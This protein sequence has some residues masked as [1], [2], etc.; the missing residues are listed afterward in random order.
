MKPKTV[1]RIK[2]GPTHYEVV[3]RPPPITEGEETN[4]I[5]RVLYNSGQLVIA[6]HLSPEIEILTILH[7]VFHVMMS[8]CGIKQHDE[9]F[10][11][12]ASGYL[13]DLIR[14]NPKLIAAIQ[15][16]KQ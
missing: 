11:E 3:R 6:D 15:A 16:T 13:L 1:S 14:D 9:P 7:E 12:T 4:V 5:G 8:H 10:V 2:V